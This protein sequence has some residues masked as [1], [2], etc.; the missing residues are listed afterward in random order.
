MAQHVGSTDSRVLDPGEPRSERHLGSRGY[1][2]AIGKPMLSLT[3]VGKA[4]ARLRHR[5]R[6]GEATQERRIRSLEHIGRPPQMRL[7]PRVFLEAAAASPR[8]LNNSLELVGPPPKDA[9]K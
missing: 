8:T 7:H 5:R 6:R 3:G 1:R 2:D 4:R 9:R